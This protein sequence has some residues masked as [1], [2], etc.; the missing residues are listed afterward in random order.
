[1][2]A[3]ELFRLVSNRYKDK[4]DDFVV[5]IGHH[6]LQDMTKP[7]GLWNQ[8]EFVACLSITIREVRAFAE[9]IES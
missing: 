4:P 7:M 3:Q 5:S 8:P 6:S 1:M 9:G 2:S